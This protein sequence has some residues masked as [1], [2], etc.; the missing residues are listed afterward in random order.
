MK[1]KIRYKFSP[2]LKIYDKMLN[3]WKPYVMFKQPQNTNNQI[4]KTDKFGMRYTNNKKTSETYSLFNF[5]EKNLDKKQIAIVGGS[6]AFGVGATDDS[7][8]IS[9]FLASNID[10]DVFNLGF[11]AF[12]HFQEL[13]MFQQVMHKF[14]NLKYVILFSGFNDI[15][16]SKYTQN[17]DENDIPFFFESEFNHRMNYP[18]NSI[19]KSLLYNILPKNFSERIN[20][21]GD[22]KSQIFKKLFNKAPKTEKE[23]E[24]D[25]WKKKYERNLNI[26]KI[27]SQSLNFK[28]IFALQPFINWT[29]KEFSEE[30]KL[31]FE[32]IKDNNSEK[33][34]NV[35]NSIKKKEH[36]DASNFFKQVCENNKFDFIDTNNFI[37][38]ETY[39]KKWF[40]VDSVHLNDYGYSETANHLTKLING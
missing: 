19:S 15:F 38:N 25:E 7:K 21:T 18:Q 5:P 24:K 2:Q 28:I 29:S 6:T 40:F 4:F 10:Y 35:L 9:S 11:R 34:M 17:S 13:I 36:Y 22:N 14:N 12:N 3:N 20:W 26:W 30:E 8:T 16:F 23:N 32:E 39:G 27:I 33:V 37:N 31:I 1:S